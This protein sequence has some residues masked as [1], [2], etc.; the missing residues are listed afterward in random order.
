M[1]EATL[2][3]V[4]EETSDDMLWISDTIASPQAAGSS[5]GCSSSWSC[6]GGC[7]NLDDDQE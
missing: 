2:D 5:T 6:D 4:A 1:P 7:T 3:L